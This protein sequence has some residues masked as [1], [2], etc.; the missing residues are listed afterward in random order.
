M[1]NRIGRLIGRHQYLGLIAGM[2]IGSSLCESIACLLVWSKPP[3]EIEA[4]DFNGDGIV[5]RVMEERGYSFP[6]LADQKRYLS[7][8]QEGDEYLYVPEYID[9]D[10]GISYFMT[11][12]HQ[13]YFYKNY[14]DEFEEDDED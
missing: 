14:N 2:I 8:S 5:D 9:E 3:V 4:R 7:L 12:S 6:S 11:S 13:M 1:I 10:N